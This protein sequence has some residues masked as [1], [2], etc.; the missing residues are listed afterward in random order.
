MFEQNLCGLYHL[1]AT[2]FLA[3]QSFLFWWVNHPVIP[4]DLPLNFL[5]KGRLLH[6]QPQASLTGHLWMFCW[7]C[8]ELE[9]FS[10]WQCLLFLRLKKHKSILL[11]PKCKLPKIRTHVWFIFYSYTIC[12]AHSSLLTH[13]EGINEWRVNVESMNESLD[14]AVPQTSVLVLIPSVMY[15][16]NIHWVAITWKGIWSAMHGMGIFMLENSHFLHWC[17]CSFTRLV[18]II[19]YFLCYEHVV[20]GVMDVKNYGLGLA[21]SG[22]QLDFTT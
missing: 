18:S 15:S 7:P 10:F 12:T 5:F 13:V 3:R 19:E 17:I 21:I 11:S 9:L 6:V 1:N 8:P 14:S 20:S 16:G 2:I 22:F 4:H